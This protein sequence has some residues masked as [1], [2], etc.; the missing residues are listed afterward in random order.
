MELAKRSLVQWRAFL[1]AVLK[2]R[3]LVDS[4]SSYFSDSSEAAS[5]SWVHPSKQRNKV[6]NF[7]SVNVILCPPYLD[8]GE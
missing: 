5:G 7:A 2:L 3:V 4:D 1:L 8:F 6:G